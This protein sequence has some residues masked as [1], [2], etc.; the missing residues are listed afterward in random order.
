LLKKNKFEEFSNHINPKFFLKSCKVSDKGKEFDCENILSMLALRKNRLNDFCSLL[1]TN[2]NSTQN[3]LTLNNRERFKN[4]EKITIK[5]RRI[6]KIWLYMFHYCEQTHISECYEAFRIENSAN[7]HFETYSIQKLN[8]IRYKCSEKI[9][10]SYNYSMNCFIDCIE[11]YFQNFFG[12]LPIDS[13]KF[14]LILEKDLQTSRFKLCSKRNFFKNPNSV[15]KLKI[16]ENYNYCRTQCIPDCNRL[17]LI[18]RTDFSLSINESEDIQINLIPMNKFVIRYIEIFQN[19]LNQLIYEC[20]GIL[21]LWFGIYPVKAVDLLIYSI[22]RIKSYLVL[23]LI[24]SKKLILI[25]KI[26]LILLLMTLFDTIVF[27][28]KFFVLIIHSFI[29]YLKKLLIFIKN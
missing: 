24:Y 1:F 17:N 28:M 26:K 5:L 25:I 7:F 8:T 6:K 3:N 4:L 19:D 9:N 15:K 16:D 14:N 13:M 21:G 12:C 20:G 10:N 23:I 22:I 11:N 18:Y 29:N 2:W 27:V